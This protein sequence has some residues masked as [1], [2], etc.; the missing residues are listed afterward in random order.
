L[1]A[2]AAPTGFDQP[3]LLAVHWATDTIA[4]EHIDSSAVVHAGGAIE[5]RE[6]KQGAPVQIVRGRASAAAFKE[7]SDALID[8]QI[9]VERGGCGGPTADGPL[10]YEVTWYGQGPRYNTFE[11]GADLSGC[12]TGLQK[13]IRLLQKVIDDVR[14]APGSQTFPRPRN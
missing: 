5:I 10:A 13:M 2:V 8:G 3:P 6:I 1:A 12:S 7:L 11:V 14:P 4:G 9:G